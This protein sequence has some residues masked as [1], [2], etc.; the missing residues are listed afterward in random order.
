MNKKLEQAK[1]RMKTFLGDSEITFSIR[2]FPS[3]EWIAECNEIPA[4]MTGG[5]NGDITT[6]DAMIR[7]AIITAV[8]IDSEYTN[9]VLR[10]NGLKETNIRNAEYA[11]A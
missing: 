8:G 11:V 7:D 5:M 2:N 9:D 6:I 1:L 10:F 4:I 3:G